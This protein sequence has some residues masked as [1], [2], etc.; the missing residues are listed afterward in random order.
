MHVDGAYGG[1]ARSLDELRPLFTGIERAD[2]IAFDP[3]KW[4]Y[5]PH[6]GGCVLVRDRRVLASLRRAGRA[7]S[8]EDEER[9]GHGVDFDASD[10]S[11]AGGSRP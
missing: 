2:S 7:T 5:T 11:S 8:H 1:P 4:M 6:S 9:T 10:R 3:H